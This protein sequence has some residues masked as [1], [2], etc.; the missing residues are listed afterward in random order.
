MRRQSFSQA[1][2]SSR[3]AGFFRDQLG[4]AKRLGDIGIRPAAVCNL[5]DLY[6]QSHRSD[7]CRRLWAL[8]VLDQS[9]AGLAAVGAR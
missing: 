2:F 8:V 6:D 7:H 4:D 5:L 1:W 3:L 9:L